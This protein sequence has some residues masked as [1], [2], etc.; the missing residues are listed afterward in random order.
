MRTNL[1]Q[2]SAVL[3]EYWARGIGMV[4]KKDPAGKQMITELALK[5]KET[6]K[7]IER[8]IRNRR[9]KAKKQMRPHQQA[10]RRRNPLLP[11]KKAMSGYDLYKK[12]YLTG[13]TSQG[14]TADAGT[15]WT[16][17]STEEKEEYKRK[18]KMEMESSSGP[19]TDEERLSAV[20][21]LYKQMRD[22]IAAL[23]AAGCD[24]LCLVYNHSS[25]QSFYSGTPAACQFIE[26]NK[27]LEWN[28]SSCVSRSKSGSQTDSHRRDLE[29]KAMDLLNQKYQISSGREARFPYAAYK[30]GLVVVEGLPPG[31]SLKK[32]GKMGLQQ[33]QQLLACKDELLVKGEWK[34][35]TYYNQ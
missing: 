3:E 9:D 22:T 8:W 6:E 26:D 32:P 5:T 27:E 11:K 23:K 12:D 25:K 15:T 18:A 1:S 34:P 14:I 24:T 16:S 10:Q 31:F 30:K 29:K 19:P 7:T 17:L 28:F 2:H 35:N 33:L 21:A 20:N 4:S 13:K